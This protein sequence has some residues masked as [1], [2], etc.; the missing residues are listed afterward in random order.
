M[1]I[2]TRKTQLNGCVSTRSLLFKNMVVS[3]IKLRVVE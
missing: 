3:K 1:W 2:V